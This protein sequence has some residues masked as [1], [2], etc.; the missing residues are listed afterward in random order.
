MAVAT[1]FDAGRVPYQGAHRK[2]MG[3]GPTSG[4]HPV[5]STAQ[6]FSEVCLTDPGRIRT[7][8]LFGISTTPRG[9]CGQGITLLHGRHT[10]HCPQ[11]RCT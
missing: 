4:G 8:Q 10:V 1:H 2:E 7:L 6:G 9:A 5:R 3:Y 11:W